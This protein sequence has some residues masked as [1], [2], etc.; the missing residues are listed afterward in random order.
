MALCRKVAAAEDCGNVEVWVDGS[1]G[2]FYTYVIEIV[3]GI[4][5]LMQSYLIGAVNIGCSEVLANDHAE[6]DRKW[7]INNCLYS[8]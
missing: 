5:L 6:R 1:A 4:D 3:D 8:I 7:H 2:R